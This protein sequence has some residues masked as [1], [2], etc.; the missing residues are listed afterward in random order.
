MC[1]LGPFGNMIWN[2]SPAAVVDPQVG[3]ADV[4]QAFPSDCRFPAQKNS[5]PRAPPKGP[6][7]SV[8][9]GGFAGPV[10]SK[11]MPIQTPKLCKNNCPKNL[12]QE[13]TNPLCY[14]LFGS[15]WSSG[16]PLDACY[17]TV[18]PQDEDNWYS[19]FPP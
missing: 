5:G 12:K 2:S 15:G 19:G 9:G 16:S 3:L 11:G 17:I 10:P 4:D 1:V 13:P 18:G 6:S 8:D 14:I 7:V